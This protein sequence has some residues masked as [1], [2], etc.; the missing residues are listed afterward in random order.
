MADGSVE[1]F[2]KGIILE[3]AFVELNAVGWVSHY[4]TPKDIE[5]NAW[6]WVLCIDPNGIRTRGPR[7]PIFLLL[8]NA[9]VMPGLTDRAGSFTGYLNDNQRRFDDDHKYGGEVIH[10]DMYLLRDGETYIL[11]AD[12]YWIG[13]QRGGELKMFTS[14]IFSKTIPTPVYPHEDLFCKGIIGN[15]YNY[16]DL[17]AEGWI[18][19]SAFIGG[20]EEFLTYCS[21]HGKDQTFADYFWNKT[22]DILTSDDPADDPW[23]EGRGSD[24]KGIGRKWIM[25]GYISKRY[26]DYGEDTRITAIIRGKDYLDLWRDQPFGTPDIPRNYTT[27]TDLATI[28]VD[29]LTDINITTGLGTISPFTQ[30]PSYWPGAGS[31]PASTGTEWVKEFKQEW[32]M[33]VMRAA[34]EEIGWEWK[35]NHKKEVLF[36]PRTSAPEPVQPLIQ[37]SR[38]I[39]SLPEIC[40]GDTTELITNVI[41]TDGSS[42][43]LPDDVDKWCLNADDWPDVSNPNL[44]FSITNF[45]YPPNTVDYLY[46]DSTLTFDDEGHPALCFIK[47]N[48]NIFDLAL[49]FYKDSAGNPQ[50][51]EMQ[52]DIRK[53]RRIKFR[54]RHATRDPNYEYGGIS[55]TTGS[56]Y[57]ILLKNDLGHGYQY[58]FGKGTANPLNQ[59]PQ[60]GNDLTDDDTITGQEFND[61]DLILPEPDVDGVVSNANLKGWTR[62]GSYTGSTINYIEFYIDPA[63]PDPGPINPLLA[64]GLA[65]N[66]SSGDQYINL[67]NPERLAGYLGGGSVRKEFT[68]GVE[69]IMKKGAT[70]ET[71]FINGINGQYYPAG[72]NTRLDTPAQNSFSTPAAAYVRVGWTIA[73][74]QLRLE[75]ALRYDEQALSPLGPPYRYKLVTK[76]EMEYLSEATS[77]AA[78]ALAQEASPKRY[79]DLHIDDPDPNIEIGTKVRIFLD[80]GHSKIFQNIPMIVDDI[81]YDL[82]NQ[83]KLNQRVML[84]P[85][86]ENIK[87]RLKSTVTA[88]DTLFRKADNLGTKSAKRGT[89]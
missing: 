1:L 5:Q 80:P 51:A 70:E 62:I 78:L 6:A 50:F 14:S 68:P 77:N 12:E 56:S 28:A 47:N 9:I 71:L 75:R 69:V 58:E 48:I 49:A 85:A 36:Y 82:E 23:Y 11:D 54:F 38:N 39:K 73:F 89:S 88:L 45:P 52:I 59:S 44:V 10:W 37:Y 26:Y 16:R 43:T 87:A 86:N 18:Y 63:E 17:H 64:V 35:I 46:S 2:A 81:S 74:S 15:N 24:G 31:I 76:K 42:F 57:R 61:I 55:Y 67:S 72:K 33:D 83:V 34:C 79:V 65:S 32:A 27:A 40:L 21:N 7:G 66:I 30:S 19:E 53:W 13:I 22:P 29:I 25:G 4:P 3:S 20:Y 84:S 60:L 41:V 8:D